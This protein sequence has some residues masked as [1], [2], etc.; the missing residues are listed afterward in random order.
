MAPAAA[1]VTAEVTGLSSINSVTSLIAASVCLLM[2]LER[3]DM[4]FLPLFVI[5]LGDQASLTQTSL[6]TRLGS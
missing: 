1:A 2:R 5:L 3:L 4:A 6:L